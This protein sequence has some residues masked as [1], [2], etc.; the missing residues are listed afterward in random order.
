MAVF[1]RIFL[2]YGKGR[3]HS[4]NN[5]QVWHSSTESV[6]VY[7]FILA[8]VSVLVKTIHIVVLIESYDSQSIVSYYPFA[9]IAFPIK[10]VNLCSW[11]HIH[12]V[13]HRKICIQ[14]A[15]SLFCWCY[16]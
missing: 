3:R 13:R 10:H 5:R 4:G 7:V 9:E 2:C 16:T 6:K 14:Q 12:Q 1:C 8:Y 11:R 15:H